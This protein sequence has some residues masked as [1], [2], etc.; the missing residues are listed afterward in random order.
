MPAIVPMRSLARRAALP[1]V[2]PVMLACLAL[3]ACDDDPFGLQDWPPS[4]D[5][6]LLY[7]LARPELNLPAAANIHRQFTLIV[8]SPS[9]TGNWDIALDTR[10]GALVFL[11]PLAVGINSQAR[12]SVFPD[13]TFED[14]TEAPSDTTRYQPATEPVPVE[15]GTTYVV[16]TSEYLT[17]FNQRCV[18]YG[19]VEPLEIDVDA[20][21]V[22]FVTDSNPNC[23]QLS[24]VPSG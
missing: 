11:T 16:R 6:M 21:T 4:P 19:K 7:S 3:G 24:L 23:R 22:R 12:I 15:L 14:V 20:G 10:D 18:F 13:M 1:F 17:A 8:E 2:V 9:S 5:T